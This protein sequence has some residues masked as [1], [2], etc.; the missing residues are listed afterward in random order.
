MSSMRIRFLKELIAPLQIVWPVFSGLL[1][2]MFLLGFIISRI[3]G[4]QALDGLYFACI[5]GLTV[6]YGDLV[7]TH[8]ISRIMAIGIGF[9]GM[10]L[11]ALVAAIGVRALQEAAREHRPFTP[12]AGEAH[13][14]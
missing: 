9:T 10:L 6:G 12:N 5:T 1:A 11:A 13:R 4:W 14:D 3:E 7:P 2:T 8:L